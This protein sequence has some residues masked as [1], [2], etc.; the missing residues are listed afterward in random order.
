MSKS[1]WL[2]IPFL[3]F[4]TSCA[5]PEEWIGFFATTMHGE[6]ER[7]I[8]ELPDGEHT[9]RYWS[10]HSSKSYRG[11][12]WGHGMVKDG[13]KEGPWTFYY[14]NGIPK[15]KTTYERG[16]MNGVTS[17]YWSRGWLKE[18]GMVKN[19]SRVGEWESYKWGETADGYVGR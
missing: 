8:S 16:V 9:L 10:G 3:F 6:T 7:S 14:P 1:R 11:R 18:R 15:M 19:G 4:C 13:K 5:S 2:L 17:Y 12:K